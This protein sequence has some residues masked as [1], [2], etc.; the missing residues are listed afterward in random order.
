MAVYGKKYWWK[1]VTSCRKCTVCGKNPI[2]VAE[3]ISGKG[4]CSSCAERCQPA[5]E[6]ARKA[7]YKPSEEFVDTAEDDK[8]LME[9]LLKE[10]GL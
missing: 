5:L 2:V 8:E 10:L 6:S 1:F 4:L 7:L 3:Q 9:D